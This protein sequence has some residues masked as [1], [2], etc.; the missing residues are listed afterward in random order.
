MSSVATFHLAPQAADIEVALWQARVLAQGG[1]LSSSSVS[2]ALALMRAIRATTFNFK[3]VY[4]LP[5]L[6]TNAKACCV[7][8]R[9]NSATRNSGFAD[10]AFDEHVGLSNPTEASNLLDTGIA[11]Q[12]LGI[13]T[14][15][16][17]FGWWELNWGNGAGVEPMGCYNAANTRR[18]VLDI[19]SP[20][21]GTVII[22]DPAGSGSTSGRNGLLNGHHYGQRVS[23]TLVE[24]YGNG[25]FAAQGTTSDTAAADR[26]TVFVMGGNEN[27]AQTGAFWK[28]RCGVAY[29]T[30]GTLSRSEVSLM[31]QILGSI[32]VYGMGRA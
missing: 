30:D 23:S 3:L 13:G 32:L 17:G 26:R 15:V 24:I 31:H 20:T 22:G 19:R 8:L 28:G 16:G 5:F 11:F 6:G 10:S 25:E 9:G 2:T 7:P 27:D 12:N 4:L 18:F 1:T 14:N 29:M 21:G